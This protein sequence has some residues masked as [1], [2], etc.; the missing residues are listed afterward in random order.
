MCNAPE[1]NRAKIGPIELAIKYRGKSKKRVSIC[2]VTLDKDAWGVVLHL[3][4]Y[5]VAVFAHAV[6][7]VVGCYTRV[8]AAHKALHVVG[9][10]MT[11]IAHTISRATLGML[12][13]FGYC[14]Q[15]AAA[16][17]MAAPPEFPEAKSRG[18]VD[19][20]LLF[21]F[22]KGKMKRVFVLFGLSSTTQTNAAG[23]LSAS[24]R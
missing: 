9:Y 18:L 10:Y 5:C 11:V 6:S 2:P 17:V 14:I 22:P 21:S 19:L 8:A 16:A 3:V 15:D 12:L 20:F 4:N 7:H 24:N 13:Q 23:G 1:S